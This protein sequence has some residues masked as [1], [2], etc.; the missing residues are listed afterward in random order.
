MADGKSAGPAVELPE[1]SLGDPDVKVRA[2]AAVAEVEV[3]TEA[4]VSR[5]ADRS[6]CWA[7][8]PW[9]SPSSLSAS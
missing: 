3:E 6:F 5:E 8:R 1:D 7:T 4:E 9:A 2:A